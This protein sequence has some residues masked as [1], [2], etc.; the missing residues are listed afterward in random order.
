MNTD[1]ILDAIRRSRRPNDDTIYCT[2]HDRQKIA[3]SI[4]G[5]S[6]GSSVDQLKVAG[7]EV[8]PHNKFKGPIVCRKGDIFPLAKEYKDD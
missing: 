3:D 8:V 4:S 6:A 7:M 1:D 2:I 5:I